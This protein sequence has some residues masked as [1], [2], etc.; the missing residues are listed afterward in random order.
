[1]HLAL[2]SAG[3]CG[4]D[5][6]NHSLLIL[7]ASLALVCTLLIPGG[8]S[9]VVREVSE[10]HPLQIH[11][12]VIHQTTSVPAV[13]IIAPAHYTQKYYSNHGRTNTA[14]TGC[15]QRPCNGHMAALNVFLGKQNDTDEPLVLALCL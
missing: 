5:F 13:G 6:R 7:H 14:R 1:M 12:R 8:Q 3:I 11:P 15:M 4:L 2:N 9:K 10:F